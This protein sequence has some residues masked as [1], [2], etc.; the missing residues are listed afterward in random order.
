V[1]RLVEQH[2]D[3]AREDDRRTDAEAEIPRLL[4]FEQRT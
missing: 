3:P 4:E 2:R 1:A